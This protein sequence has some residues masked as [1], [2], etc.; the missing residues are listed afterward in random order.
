MGRSTREK[1]PLPSMSYLYP[2]KVVRCGSPQEVHVAIGPKS[3]GGGG[4]GGGGTGEGKAGGR[5]GSGGG[6]GGGGGFSDSVW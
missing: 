1:A 4:K 3:G 5:D 6:M 2:P